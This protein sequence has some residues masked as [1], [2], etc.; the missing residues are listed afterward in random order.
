MK[1]IL[2]PHWFFQKL[3]DTTLC[4]LKIV[5]HAQSGVIVECD[6]STWRE[7][8]RKIRRRERAG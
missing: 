7:W 1:T 8:R 4:T 5:E 2:L 3:A 6:D